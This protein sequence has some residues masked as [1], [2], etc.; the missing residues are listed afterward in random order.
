MDVAAE[1]WRILMAFFVSIV[2][3]VAIA[4]SV[5]AGRAQEVL[6]KFQDGR[7]VGEVD[8]PAG[9]SVTIRTQE[10]LGELVVG[11]TDV[12]DVFPLTETSL[13]VLGKAAGRTNIAVYSP[14]RVLLG[15]IDVEV[16]V[17]VA[18]L[19]EALRQAAPSAEIDVQTVNGRLRLGGSVPDA[20]TLDKVLEIARQYSENVVNAIQVTKAQQVTLAVRL[21]EANRNAGRELGVSW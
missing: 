20:I 14:D 1:R 3:L 18:D 19:D 4:L 7:G 8:V 16:G 11:D 6:I 9:Q 13:Y 21:L 5:S 15:V 12:A 10:K 17:D 2:A